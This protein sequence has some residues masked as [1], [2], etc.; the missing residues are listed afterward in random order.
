MLNAMMKLYRSN[1]LTSSGKASEVRDSKRKVV[2]SP[3]A[4]QTFGNR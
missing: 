3:L 4:V 2:S 1:P